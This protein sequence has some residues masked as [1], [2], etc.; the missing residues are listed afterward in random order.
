[1]GQPTELHPTKLVSPA[2]IVKGIKDR[3]KMML[4]SL[5]GGIVALDIRES[6]DSDQKRY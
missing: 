2:P 3:A 4:G 5:K 1:M 6:Q